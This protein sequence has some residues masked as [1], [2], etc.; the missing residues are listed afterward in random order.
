MKKYAH[1]RHYGKRVLNYRTII[2]SLTILWCAV[3]SNY[4]NK[5]YS[6]QPETEQTFLVPVVVTPEPTIEDKIKKYFPRSWKTMIAIAHAESGMD[7]SAVGY[8]CY[9]TKK[10]TTKY[11]P[12]PETMGIESYKKVDLIVHSTKVKGSFSAACKKEHRNYAWSVDCGVLQRNYK[13]K[14]C[15][16]ISVDEHLEEVAKLSKVQG[17]QAWAAYNNNSYKKYL[18]QNK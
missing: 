11:Y 5:D 7:H 9:Y 14:V 2:L 4:S 15:P 16:D 18:A 13:G 10:V 12:N 8:N 6:Y 1:S 17:F 3:V